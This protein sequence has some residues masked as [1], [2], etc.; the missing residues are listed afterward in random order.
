MV[1]Y[2][3]GKRIIIVFLFFCF[4]SG[5]IFLPVIYS[6]SNHLS[7]TERVNANIL[8]VEGWLPVYAVEEA[9]NEFQNND[10]AHIITTGLKSPDY[11]FMGMNGYLIF[12]PERVISSDNELPVHLIAVDAYSEL[13]GKNSSRFNVYVNDSLISDFTAEK[14]RRKYTVPWKGK[15]TNIRSVMVQFYNDEEGN[16]GD[17]NLYVKEVIIDDRIK[18]PYQYNSDYDIEKLDGKYM[19]SNNFSS[20]AQLARS[21][22]IL[23]GIDSALVTSIPGNIAKINRTLTSA[24]AFRDWLKTTDIEIKG[25]NIVTMGTHARRTWMTYN[26]I[27][28]KSYGIGIISLP[29]RK[30]SHSRRHKII[31]TLRETLGLVYYWIILLP[32]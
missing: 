31:K 1:K 29:D 27:L 5:L 26:K 8:L 19:I 15:L 4:L 11:Y 16:F 28:K 10:Y 25:I 3:G 14:T 23:L 24:L 32:Y 30:D 2:T 6:L 21:R 9:Y 13:G 22:L 17:R 20:D 7:K 18:I 12:Y